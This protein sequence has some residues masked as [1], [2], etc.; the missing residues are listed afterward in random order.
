MSG[1]HRPEKSGRRFDY[2]ERSVRRAEKNVT[3]FYE[4]PQEK[5]KIGIGGTEN[6]SAV[7]SDGVPAERKIRFRT[8]REVASI[9]PAETEWIAYPYVAKGAITEVDGKIK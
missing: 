9:T 7:S 1:L 2:L 6:H 5:I 4:W 3:W 8:A